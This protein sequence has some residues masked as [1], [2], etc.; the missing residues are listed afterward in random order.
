M[1]A[2]VWVRRRV[3]SKGEG[4]RGDDVKTIEIDDIQEGG[5]SS[6]SCVLVVFGLDF[7]VCGLSTREIILM[8]IARRGASLLHCFVLLLDVGYAI[9]FWIG[10]VCCWGQSLNILCIAYDRKSIPYF[11]RIQHGVPLV[12]CCIRSCLWKFLPRALRNLRPTTPNNIQIHHR[13]HFI[14]QSSFIDLTSTKPHLTYR[15]IIQLSLF[16]H[17]L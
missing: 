9:P 10:A 6:S 2:L 7:G 14:R 11:N 3:W 12:R 5:G 13:P 16:H 4:E 17:I 1:F 15:Q 8:H